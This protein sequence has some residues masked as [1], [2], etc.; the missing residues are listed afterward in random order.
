MTARHRPRR[1]RSCAGGRW[2]L[3]GDST[4]TVGTAEFLLQ[5]SDLRSQNSVLALY[6]IT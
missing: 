5:D 3:N 4:A 6:H 1:A 2:R